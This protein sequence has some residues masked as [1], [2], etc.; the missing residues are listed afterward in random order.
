MLLTKTDPATLAASGLWSLLANKLMISVFLFLC[1]MFSTDGFTVAPWARSVRE[2]EIITLYGDAAT[3]PGCLGIDEI[4]PWACSVTLK[5]ALDSQ[6][7]VADL[8]SEKSER[9]TSP[10]SLDMVHRLRRVSDA[11]LVGRSTVEIDDCTLTVRR[12]DPL[13]QSDGSP[14]QPVRVIIDPRL[15]I[16]MGNHKIAT[17]G[18]STVIVHAMEA[19]RSGEEGFCKTTSTEFPNVVYLGLPPG[20]DGGLSPKLICSSLSKEFHIQHV[21]LEGGAAT[22]RRFL[23]HKMVDRAIVVH[24]PLTFKEPLQSNISKSSLEEAGLELVGTSMIGVDTVEYYSRPG[25][26][27]PAEPVSFWP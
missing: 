22:A 24:A 21:M 7:G 27:W 10:G 23:E 11:V 2:S 3:G 14:K 18:L 13:V 19:M 5:I 8:S 16:E 17:D 15:G 20:P 6:G 26:P 9:F 4:V 12:V 1:C 25:L